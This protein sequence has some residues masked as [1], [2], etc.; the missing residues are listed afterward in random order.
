MTL[1]THSQQTLRDLVHRYEIK[2]DLENG[3]IHAL[4]KPREVEEMQRY[5]GKLICLPVELCS[6]GPGWCWG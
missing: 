2:C 6:G 1:D 3:I 5:L 4:S